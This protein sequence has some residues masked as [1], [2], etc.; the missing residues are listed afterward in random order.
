MVQSLWRGICQY[1]AKLHMYLSFEKFI[2]LVRICTKETL[3]EVKGCLHKTINCSTIYI[4]KELEATQMPI[5]R[6]RG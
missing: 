1:L 6:E 3:A 2:P 5:N 4:S